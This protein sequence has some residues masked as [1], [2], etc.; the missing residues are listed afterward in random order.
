MIF[1][2]SQVTNN[3]LAKWHPCFQEEG[4]SVDWR[5]NQGSLIGRLE[6]WRSKVQILV[7]VQIFL[8][9]SDNTIGICY[10][11]RINHEDASKKMG[12]I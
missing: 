6:I 2:H 4:L 9:K 7:Q 11:Q 5:L 1:L 10:L 8:L 12:I 3:C